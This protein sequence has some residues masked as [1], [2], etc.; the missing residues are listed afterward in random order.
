M[1]LLVP[2]SVGLAELRAAGR[3]F[4]QVAQQ[5]GVPAQAAAQL[6]KAEHAALLQE[7]LPAGAVI[8]MA[9]AEY[10]LNVEKKRLPFFEAA[11]G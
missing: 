11:F 2:E 5:A 6:R 10:M 7:R 1:V 3:L 4:Q 8:T 9:K